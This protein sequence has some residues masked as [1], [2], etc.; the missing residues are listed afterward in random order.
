MLPAGMMS[1]LKRYF[2]AVSTIFKMPLMGFKLPSKDNSPTNIR[3]CRSFANSCRER[4]RIARVI[5]RS[6]WVLS[7]RSS[8]GARLIIILCRGKSNK[9]LRRAERM[10]SRLSVIILPGIPTILKAGR[11]RVASPS[12]VTR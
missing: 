7:L 5:G 1:C 10:R 4:L 2:L 8:A 11:P 3:F 6:R 12:T 9:E